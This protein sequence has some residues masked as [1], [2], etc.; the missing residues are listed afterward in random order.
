[1]KRFLETIRQ[2]WGKIG[3]LMFRFEYLNKEKMN[4]AGESVDRFGEFS[5]S[6]LKDFIYYLEIR[7]SNYLNKKYLSIL[8]DTIYALPIFALYEQLWGYVQELSVVPLLGGDRKGIEQ[9][10]GK[11]SNEVV[12]P[13]DHDIERL[14]QLFVDLRSQSL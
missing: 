12:E 13:K 2:L 10:N 3:P 6:L 1:M 11:K 14:A 8:Q 5:A 9:K 4:G 7:N